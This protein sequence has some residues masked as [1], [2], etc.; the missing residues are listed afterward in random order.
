[1]KEKI[2]MMKILFISCNVNDEGPSSMVVELLSDQ[3]VVSGSG[4]EAQS[5]I[6]II[7][8]EFLLAEPEE[9]RKEERI[10]RTF[11]QLNQNLLPIGILPLSQKLSQTLLVF[12]YLREGNRL[13]G[14]N[15]KV[16]ISALNKDAAMYV[17]DMIVMSCQTIG[18][19]GLSS[20]LAR[21]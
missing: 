11:V 3:K 12:R 19:D 21:I 4:A 15:K 20:V 14:G 16:I 10:G 17:V 6:F 2:F 18:H 9:E 13:S 7:L 1:M 5:T 8:V